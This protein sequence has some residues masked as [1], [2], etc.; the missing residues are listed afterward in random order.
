[1]LVGNANGDVVIA[2]LEDTRRAQFRI[3]INKII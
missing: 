1:M 3:N 2:Y